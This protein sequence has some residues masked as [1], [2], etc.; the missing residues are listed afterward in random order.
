MTRAGYQVHFRV[1]AAF[2][3][4]RVVLRHVHILSSVHNEHC[5]IAILVQQWPQVEGG[6]LR[7][8]LGRLGPSVETHCIGND[9]VHAKL[10]WTP[11]RC[12]SSFH[13]PSENHGRINLT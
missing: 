6:S 13:R 7:R 3:Y 12:E 10:A 8:E 4:E 2:E 9:I 5:S 1:A 11:L